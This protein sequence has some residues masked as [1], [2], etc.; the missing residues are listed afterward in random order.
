ML[1]GNKANSKKYGTTREKMP[2]VMNEGVRICC[3]TV[4]TKV[5]TLVGLLVELGTALSK[6]KGSLEAYNPIS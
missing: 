4:T 6:P 1:R 2:T 3:K 5:I